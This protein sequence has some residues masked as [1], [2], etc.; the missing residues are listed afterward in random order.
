MNRINFGI[1]L[2]AIAFGDVRIKKEK[3]RLVIIL[4]YSLFSSENMLLLEGTL[5]HVL[6]FG[7]I[8]CFAISP[9]NLHEAI[10]NWKPNF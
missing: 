3:K 4:I 5:Y 7:G 9:N 10:A 2:R 8:L 1:E 6:Y